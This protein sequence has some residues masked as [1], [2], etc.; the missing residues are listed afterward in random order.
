MKFLRGE[1][2]AICFECAN[3]HCPTT[4]KWYQRNE[5]YDW[6]NTPL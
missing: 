6:I 2:Y 5:K 1:R 4:R 3:R